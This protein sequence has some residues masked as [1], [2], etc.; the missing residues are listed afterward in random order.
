[1]PR[2]LF[3][4]LALALLCT[5]LVM[6]GAWGALRGFRPHLPGF[7]AG[8]ATELTTQQ[9][10]ATPSVLGSNTDDVIKTMQARVRMKPSEGR[11]YIVLGEAYLQKARETG[12]PTYYTKAEAVLKEGVKLE[13]LNADGI[14]SQ[15]SL[16]LSRHEFRD[17]LRLG[18]EAHALN[19][20]SA[21]AL[22]VV[23][24]AQVELGDYPAAIQTFQAMVDLRP[25]LS[26][27]ARVSYMRELTG[28]MQGAIEAMQQAATSG[29]PSP[30]N[31]AWTGWQLGTLYFNTGELDAAQRQYERAL[32]LV[33]NYVHAEAGMAMVAA[34]RGDFPTAIA[35]YTTANSV[36]PVPAYIAALGD[37]YAAL[38]HPQ[39]AEQQY[40]LVDAIQKLYQANGV[41]S[42]MEIALFDADHRRNMQQ[43]VPLARQAWRE[44][45]SVMGA[46]ALAW[47]LYQSGDCQGA[48]AA[49]KDALRLG[50]RLPIMLF[51]A[52]MIADCVGDASAAKNYLEATVSMNPHFSTLYEGIAQQTLKRI[53]APSA[54]EEP[55]KGHD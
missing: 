2:R 14:T 50:T 46:D 32:S 44:R 23:G 55:V 12:D 9:G 16:A 47:T 1:V 34:A 28:D 19:P 17:A 39:E 35:R 42:D 51:H 21:V 40:G 54:S 10:D 37:V 13:P 6:S 36:M 52:G 27:Y 3:E 24:D 53:T 20:Y 8:V 15:G 38:G 43:A 30:E 45:P 4:K 18:Q 11:G 29:G 5:V 41:N 48:A 7:H 31:V 22:G 49:Q 25:D 26:S 33:P